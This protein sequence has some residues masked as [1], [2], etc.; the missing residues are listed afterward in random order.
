MKSVIE[1]GVRMLNLQQAMSY[2]GLGRNS[3]LQFASKCGCMRRYGRR[4]LYDKNRIDEALDG[5][6]STQTELKEAR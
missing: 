5:L 2:V 6:P 4:V 1:P 3:F